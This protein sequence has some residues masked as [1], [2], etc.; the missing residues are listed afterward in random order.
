MYL[1]KPFGVTGSNVLQHTLYNNLT[2]VNRAL[3]MSLV[4]TKRAHGVQNVNT[5]IYKEFIL[6]SGDA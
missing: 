6:I 5:G 1:T 3:P 2:F 4:Y